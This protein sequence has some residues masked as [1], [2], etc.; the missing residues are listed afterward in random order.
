M[1][2]TNAAEASENPVPAIAE[3]PDPGDHR[4]VI[5]SRF[6]TIAVAPGS[7]IEFPRGLL[8]FGE[9]F[10]GNVLL[11]HGDL[12]QPARVPYD[13]EHKASATPRAVN[14]ATDSDGFAGVLS[15]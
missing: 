13:G 11:V 6:G 2:Q 9:R 4:L 10:L 12:D 1:Y 15:L 3:A 7:A 8:G 5:E 14:P